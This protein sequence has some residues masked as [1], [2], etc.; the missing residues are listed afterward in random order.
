MDLIFPA[1][2]D[3]RP[4]RRR[5]LRLAPATSETIL[6][7]PIPTSIGQMPRAIR[8]GGVAI[9]VVTH[10]SLLCTRLCLE[11]A[12]AHTARDAQIIVVDN[13]SADGTLDYLRSL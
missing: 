5:P 13:G 2:L 12:I 1:D 3:L 11:S 7:R 10:N 9:V 4:G 8:A 6:N